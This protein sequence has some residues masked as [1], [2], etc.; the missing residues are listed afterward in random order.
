MRLQNSIAPIVFCALTVTPAFAQK[1]HKPV[2]KPAAHKAISPDPAPVEREPTGPIE[3]LRDV[4]PILDR[5]SCSTAQCH[6]K[7]GGRGGL[8]ISLLT[9]SPEDDYE[10]IVFGARGRRI[11]FAAPE[12]SLFLLKATGA[13][14]HGGGPRFSAASPQYRTLLRWIKAGAPFRDQDPRLV[15]LT[16]KPDKVTL[17]K[18][19]ATRQISVV[20][21]FTDGSTRDVTTQTVFQSTNDAVLQVGTNGLVKGIRW[22]GGAILGRYLGTITASFFTLPQ[23]LKGSYPDIPTGNVIDKMVVDNLKRLN[24]IPSDL[25]TDAEFLRRVMLDTAGRLPARQEISA[26]LDDKQPDKR[27]RLVD[28]LLES[29]D[30]VD[31][32]SLRLADLLRVNPRK[33]GNNGNLSERA[34]TLFANWIHRSVAE[35]RPWNKFVRELIVARGSEYQN[36]PACFYRVERSANDRMENLG[37]AFLGVRMS[38]ARCHKH[39]FDRWNTDDYWNFA[40]FMGKV[41][42]QGGRLDG[43]AKIVLANDAQIRNQSVTGKNRGKIAPPTFLG[44]RDAA[45]SKPDMVEALADWVTAPNNPFFA[46]AT[47]NRL[48]SYFFGRG[49]IHPVD[50]MRATTPESVPGLL[51]ALAKE[52]VDSGYDIKHVTRLILNSRTYQLS[53]V[54]NI[55]NRLDDMFFSHYRAKPMPAQALLDMINQATESKEAFGMWPEQS[56][57]VQ[58]M[59]PVGSYFLNSFG[60][61]HREFLADIDPKQ[62][63]NLVQTLLMINSPYIENKVRSGGVLQAV[64]KETQS[65]EDL[66]RALYL[67][68]FCRVPTP[69]EVKKAVALLSGVPGRQEGAQDL[70]W[71]LITAREFYFNH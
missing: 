36:G 40:A 51:D 33:F 28:K 21:T 4:A 18:V 25:S 60:Q 35:N 38:C 14:A 61:S 53:A 69:G 41:G 56:R 19:G 23:V 11:N 9:L 20:A 31:Y 66:V 1:H 67:R 63:P 45:P 55:T 8:Q 57:A 15:S 12:K 5:S 37:Q 43:E 17:A 71:A 16:L 70:L 24:V 42:T 62:E 6:G 44:D 22:G 2:R 13:V 10:P 52:L 3:F 29:P 34:A 26:F 65:S 30:Y 32:R 64:L 59:L 46:R 27:A 47:V 7:F 39:P 68:T 49:I 58:Q 54:P 50:D 48:W